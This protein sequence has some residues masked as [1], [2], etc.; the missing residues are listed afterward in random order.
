MK[1]VS[2]EKTNEMK[3]KQSKKK[4]RGRREEFQFQFLLED[5][6]EYS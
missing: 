4:E 3:T 5:I 6:I 2:E 1:E